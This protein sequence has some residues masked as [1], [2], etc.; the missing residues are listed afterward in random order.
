MTKSI[1][2]LL[3]CLEEIANIINQNGHL[4]TKYYAYFIQDPESGFQLI[5][6]ISGMSESEV[7]DD[8]QPPMFSAAVFAFEICVSQI[9]AAVESRNKTAIQLL[10]QLM[11]H[12]AQSM[13]KKDHSMDF[14]MPVISAFYDVHTELSDDL[15][16]AYFELACMQDDSDMDTELNQVS[17]IEDILEE[18]SDLSDFDIAENFFAQSYALPAE[19][20]SDLILDLYS[21]ESGQEIGVLCLLHP[22]IEVR[23]VVMVTF[24]ALIDKVTLS[25]QSLSRLKAIKNWYPKA[26]HPTFDKWI[27]VQR[28]K[29]VVF[30]PPGFNQSGVRDRDRNVIPPNIEHMHIQASDIDGGGSQGIYIHIQSQ[31]VDRFCGILLKQEVGIKDAWITPD[32]SDIEIDKYYDGSIDETITLKEVGLSYLFKMVNHFLAISTEQHLI[33]DI[34]LLDI[35]ERL[36]LVFKPEKMDMEAVLEQ[37]VVQVSPFTAERVADTLKKTKNWSKNK[38]FTEG[39]YFESPQVDKLVNQHCSFV[40]GTRV[41]DFEMAKTEVFDNLFEKDRAFWC[42]HF[43][44]VA[45]WLKDKAR[46]NE[47]AWEDCL[48]LSHCIQTGMPLKDIPI[49]VEICLQS[50]N[51]SVETMSERRTHLVRKS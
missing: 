25:S 43:M 40:D 17:N 13:L 6:V 2:T 5:D 3:K 45:M 32:L 31:G 34:H 24:D 48:I 14:W 37:L 46:S 21:I 38:S 44:W 11:S 1:E 22:K 19:F 12:L 51:Y 23:Q 47:T 26:F 35:Q 29:G 9:Q 36:G 39:W 4:D 33:P 28:K 7:M 8:V 10:Q 20:F 42:F 18:L 50:I 27:K 30:L 15:K 16:T 49:M 41:C